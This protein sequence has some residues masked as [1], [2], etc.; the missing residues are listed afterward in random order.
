MATGGRRLVKLAVTGKL[1]GG[2]A[3]SGLVPFEH[4]AI[5]VQAGALPNELSLV[6]GLTS[7]SGRLLE[8]Y[9]SRP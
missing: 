3:L 9:F 4:A 6:Y 5:E 2:D 7:V 8:L 1:A